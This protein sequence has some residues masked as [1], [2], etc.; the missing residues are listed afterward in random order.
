MVLTI[1]TVML[2]P[3]FVVG[4]HAKGSEDGKFVGHVIFVCWVQK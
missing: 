1:E 2:V 4:D 3:R